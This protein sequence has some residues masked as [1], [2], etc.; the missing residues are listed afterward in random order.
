MPPIMKSQIT[1]L[2][3]GEKWG[4]P[5]GAF[6][7]AARAIPS[8]CSNAPRATPV[9]PIPMSARNAR[10]VCMFSPDRQEV[11][12]IQE[13]VNEILAGSLRRLGGGRDRGGRPASERGHGPGPD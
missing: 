13:H 8:R 1:F 12:V 9:K 7:S 11:V 2:A 6:M 4:W 10:L 3:L 5:F